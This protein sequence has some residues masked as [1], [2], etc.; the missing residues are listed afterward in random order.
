M[1]TKVHFLGL[2]TR[3]VQAL[4]PKI[5][6]LCRDHGINKEHIRN[7]NTIAKAGLALVAEIPPSRKR[8]KLSSSCDRLGRAGN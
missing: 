4:P 5:D 8:A 7:G 3:E 6:T 1:S 2:T